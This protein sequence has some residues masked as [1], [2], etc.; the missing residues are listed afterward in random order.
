METV[1]AATTKP[2]AR[3]D[4]AVGHRLRF[5]LAA[6]LAAAAVIGFGVYGWDY[7][8]TDLAVRYDH[9]LHA[10]LRP[11][12]SIGLRLGMA[13]VGLF[14]VLFF[15]PI[16]KRIRW[17]STLG[18]TKHWLDFHAIVGITAPILITYHASFKFSGL[19]GIAYWIM[20]VVA[21]SGFIGRYLYAQI[22]R[23]MHAVELTDRELREQTSDL[24]A[25][26][27]E[28][29]LV[30][31][32]DLQPLLRVPTQDA[33]RGMSLMAILWTLLR[34]DLA[35][36]LLVA[37]L[38]RKVLSGASIVTTLGGLLPSHSVELETTIANVRRQSRLRT[39]M[40][41]LE[42]VRSVF[43]LWHVLHRPFSFSFLVLV[44]V[45][46]TVVV[47]LGYF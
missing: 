30:T 13:G 20:V 25:V 35:R 16:R 18:N 1:F 46:L 33:V 31:Q 12:G 24:T 11:S 29:N 39:K 10:Q 44:L 6:L 2:A 40:A 19:A 36:P 21:V 32:E 34:L 14:C 5:R 28:Q 22:P 37:R 3:R 47:M 38:R 42:R 45:H 17:L 15:Y 41:F 43:H 4:P 7:Y 23:S 8:M 27:S 26:I 9:P